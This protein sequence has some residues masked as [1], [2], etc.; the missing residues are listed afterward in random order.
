MPAYT[1]KKVKEIIIY[2]IIGNTL[3]QSAAQIKIHFR[4]IIRYKIQQERNQGIICDIKD[5][6]LQLISITHWQKSLASWNI[7]YHFR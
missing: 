7:F 6:E 3:E 1:M 5:Y 2:T 4:K